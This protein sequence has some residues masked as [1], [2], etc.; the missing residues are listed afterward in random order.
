MTLIRD[1]PLGGWERDAAQ[2][3]VKDDIEAVLRLYDEREADDLQQAVLE[4]ADTNLEDIVIVARWAFTL[5]KLL[6]LHVNDE[7][8][9]TKIY[10]RLTT[11]ARSLVA[12]RKTVT[13]FVEKRVMRGWPIFLGNGYSQTTFD[14]HQFGHIALGISLAA[15]AAALRGQH[16]LAADLVQSVTESL[17]DNFFAPDLEQTKLDKLGRVVAVP[18]GSSLG[19]SQRYREATQEKLCLHCPLALN[20]GI[21]LARASVE[22]LRAIRAID[23]ESPEAT[24]SSRDW[25]RPECVSRLA[26]LVRQHE[27]WLLNSLRLGPVTGSSAKDLYQGPRGTE[28]Y[29]WKYRDCTGCPEFS[30][31]VKDRYED[32]A[33]ARN[34]VSFVREVKQLYSEYPNMGIGS[35][36]ERKDVWRLMVTFLNRI[37]HDREALDGGR[38]SC[39]VA[40]TFDGDPGSEKQCGKK[41]NLRDRA[42][43]ASNWLQLAFV[44]HQELSPS[45]SGASDEDAEGLC[46]VQMELDMYQMAADVLQV[47]TVSDQS[48]EAVV[49][50]FGKKEAKNLHKWAANC[51]EAKYLFYNYE[52]AIRRLVAAQGRATA[53]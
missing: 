14:S 18:K 29:L 40:G 2:S 30:G 51:I 12:A 52:G 45:S 21:M 53:S 11:L 46:T 33:H 26:K 16:A 19:R 17:F 50:S 22:I 28:W 23:W 24:W 36:L 47:F 27:R 31:T 43:S 42:Y 8:L 38:F 37:V 41:R 20:K 7:E 4:Y 13:S 1:Q 6:D 9:N 25:R 34:E 39:D 35:R 3:A 5:S 32:I 49:F 10:D 44:A 15:R 48:G